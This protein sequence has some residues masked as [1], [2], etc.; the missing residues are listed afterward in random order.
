MNLPLNLPLI[1]P[2]LLCALGGSFFA[3][4]IVADIEA[5][6]VARSHMWKNAA[7]CAAFWIGAG[8]AL[9]GVVAP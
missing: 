1:L 8:V 6:T 4:C 3:A 5:R 2:A 7:A 9:A